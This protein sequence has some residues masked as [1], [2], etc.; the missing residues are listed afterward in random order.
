MFQRA[1]GAQDLRKVS[2]T[3]FGRSP[4]FLAHFGEPDHQPP[5]L[6]HADNSK[7]LLFIPNIQYER[8]AFSPYFYCKPAH[9]G[10]PF[11]VITGYS[12]INPHLHPFIRKLI[13]GPLG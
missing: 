7:D 3:E 1:L 13:H 10:K 6:L 2:R 5:R 12:R 9:A 8:I 4:C 11:H